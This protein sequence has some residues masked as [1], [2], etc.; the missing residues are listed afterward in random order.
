VI[1]VVGSTVGSDVREGLSPFA[2]EPFGQQRIATVLIRPSGKYTGIP[3]VVRRTVQEVAPGVPVD[4]IRPLRLEADDQIAQE[5][6]LSR[7]SLVIGG[8][9]VLLALTGL[10]AV[11][12][13]F[14]AERMRELAIRAA[15]GAN[16]GAIA[17]A[18]LG[19]VG[20]IAAAGFVAGGAIIGP[21]TGLLSAYVFGVSP[22]DPITIAASILGLAVALLVAAW[23]AVHRAIN[24]DPAQVLR[25]E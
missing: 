6:V 7:L 8:I 21:A 25:G 3:G 12:S 9:A 5:R 4:D 22:R 1:G 2:Y 14:V 23:P 20:R 19:R 18:I 11:V 24:V 10:Y 15:I 16:A 13:Q 17:M